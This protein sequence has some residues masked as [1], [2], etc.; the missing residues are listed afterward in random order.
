MRS[1]PLRW[2]YWYISC[3]SLG[4]EIRDNYVRRS[5]KSPCNFNFF[6]Y[7]VH[8]S[9][10][11]NGSCN[12]YLVRDPRVIT[13]NLGL[14]TQNRSLKLTPGKVE[15]FEPPAD[16]R[17]TNVALG[18]VIKDAGRTSVKLTFEPSGGLDEEDE[19]DVPQAVTTVLCSLK[20][21]TVREQ[22]TLYFLFYFLLVV[23]VGANLYQSCPP[24]GRDIQVRARW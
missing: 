17:I 14:L 4:S 21:D 23:L 11:K 5:F 9:R 7:R 20:P 8:S 3:S 6:S 18:D 1:S 2:L 22:F 10:H 15:T 12:W 13:S 24:G 19:D 16:L